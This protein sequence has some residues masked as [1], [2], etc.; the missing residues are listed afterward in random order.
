MQARL[1]RLLTPGNSSSVRYSFTYKA[2]DIK[3]FAAHLYPELLGRHAWWAWADLD[4]L[5]GDLL[6]YLNLAFAK[7]ACCKVTASGLGVGLGLGLGFGLGFGLACYIM[8][9]AAARRPAAACN[10]MQQTPATDPGRV[11]PDYNRVWCC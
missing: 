5:F 8:D 9:A 1:S 2:N 10:P 4:M 3:P 6:K 11:H 7:P